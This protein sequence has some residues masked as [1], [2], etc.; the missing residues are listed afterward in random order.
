VEDDHLGIL[1]IGDEARLYPRADRADGLYGTEVSMDE[2]Q[3]TISPPQRPA[4]TRGAED[5]PS[6]LFGLIAETPPLA[7]EPPAC[8]GDLNLDRVVDAIASGRDEYD[9]KPFF[10]TPLTA[11]DAVEYRHEVLRDLEADALRTQVDAFAEGMQRM[12]G[13]LRQRE[14]LRHPY[15]QKACLLEAAEIYCDSVASFAEALRACEFESRGLH[16]VA[17]FIHAYVESDRFTDLVSDTRSVSERLGG[18]RYRLHIK[19]RRVTVSEYDGEPDYSDEVAATF[20]K[21]RQG[22]VRDYRARIVDSPG[23]NHVEEAILDLVV[24]LHSE[25]FAELDRYCDRHDGFV[26]RVVATFDREVQFY[27]AFLEHR[28]KLEEVGLQW[29]HPEVADEPT[30]THARGAFDIALAGTLLEAGKAPVCN[31][32]ALSDPERIIVVTGPNQGGKTTFA[33]MFGQLHHL[34]AIGLP[35]PAASARLGLCDHLFTHFEKEENLSTGSGK[36]QDDLQRI[37]GILERTTSRSVVVMNESL[38]STTLS[39]ARR[40]GKAVIGELIERGA[41][42]VYVTFIDE[43]AQIGEETVSYVATVPRDDPASRTYKVVRMPPDGKAYAVAIAEKYGLTY[44]SLKR[45]LER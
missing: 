14:A 36:L 28:E 29:C 23:M 40:L 16:S 39:D 15:Q 21:F 12:R 42:G 1:A 33:R 17:D 26:D 6:V 25:A 35:V 44:P 30:E 41:R 7:E 5:E 11:V 4:E 3:A 38:T 43:L 18:I 22:Q 19:G 8:F 34:A 13:R 31:D 37:H 9:L 2:Q 10:Y 32:F 45:R 20:E 24:R 27:V